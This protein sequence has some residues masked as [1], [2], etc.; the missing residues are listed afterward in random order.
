MHVPELVAALNK[1]L[2]DSDIFEG[3]GLVEH[4]FTFSGLFHRYYYCEQLITLL[5][6]RTRAVGLAQCTVDELVSLWEVPLLLVV[7]KW[8]QLAPV[9][10]FSL[11]ISEVASDRAAASEASAERLI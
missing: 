3:D 8:I 7:N 5:Q 1:L 10:E 6:H 11:L 9:V 2:T 4:L